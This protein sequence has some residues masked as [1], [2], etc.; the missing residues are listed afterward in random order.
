MF[1]CADR[2]SSAGPVADKKDQ[3]EDSLNVY[4]LFGAESREPGEWKMVSNLPY[5]VASPILVELAQADLGP[6]LMVSTLQMEVA[7]RLVAC[8]RAIALFDVDRMAQGYAHFYRK[9]LAVSFRHASPAGGRAER[10]AG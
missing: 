1:I 3:I 10:E 8:A 5:S 6:K 9:A 4:R 7:R 2:W